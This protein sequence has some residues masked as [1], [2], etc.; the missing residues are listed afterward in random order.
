MQFVGSTIPDLD[1]SG[2]IFTRWYLAFKIAEG[3][4]VVFD[5]DCKS[6]NAEIFG[7]TLRDRPA[8]EHIIFLQAEIEVQC[9][10]VVAL[11]NET[12]LWSHL[13]RSPLGVSRGILRCPLNA[14]LNNG[15]E[16]LLK[17]FLSSVEPGEIVAARL[18]HLVN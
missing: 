18:F 3:K 6:A 2:A 16:E 5:L 10:G 11:N 8:L 1:C 12:R 17:L 4:I 14:H 13:G 7:Y 9:A 15:L